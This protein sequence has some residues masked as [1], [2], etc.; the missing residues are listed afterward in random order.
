[1]ESMKKP[2]SY[3]A[4]KL[5]EKIYMYDMVGMDSIITYNLNERLL[6][7]MTKDGVH[8]SRT[9]NVVLESFDKFVEQAK[10][11]YIKTLDRSNGTCFEQKRGLS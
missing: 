9:E 2:I 11:I 8:I 4:S 3:L 10:S 5:S 6:I 7:V 1:M